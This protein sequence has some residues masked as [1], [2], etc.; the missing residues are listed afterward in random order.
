MN[1]E[2]LRKKALETRN[3]MPEA[4]IA[5]KSRTVFEKLTGTGAYL[6]AVNILIYASMGSEVSTDEI[7][8]DCLSRGINVFCPKVT[9]K[10]SGIMEFVRIS[11]PEDLSEGYC[12]IREPEITEES[13]LYDGQDADR[14][15]AIMP[16]VA[17][18]EQ[19]NRIGYGGGFYDRY[20]SRYANLR[21][22]AVAFEC[23]R[24]DE[25]IDQDLRDIKPGMIIT[26]NGIC[27]QHYKY[28]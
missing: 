4:E 18:D 27:E 9:D 15:L 12:H 10:R 25:A 5:A 14:T 8:L 22:V 23:Q 13:I 2:L 11:Y 24:T 16:M 20:L 21:T 7:I 26:D 1:K 6:E 28:S 19:G 3:S 17:F